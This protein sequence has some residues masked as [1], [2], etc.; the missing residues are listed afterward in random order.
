M[1]RI[2]P[3]FK[4][5]SDTTLEQFK[6]CAI[7]TPDGYPA[8]LLKAGTTNALGNVAL[9]ADAAP[10]ETEGYQWLQDAG[11][12]CW[13]WADGSGIVKSTLRGIF[14]ADGI[15][16]NAVGDG[17]TILRIDKRTSADNPIPKWNVVDGGVSN[18]LYSIK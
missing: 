1:L 9:N 4:G 10:D 14:S 16:I 6:A 18:P 12:F 5:G 7:L 2:H 15:V 8:P 13:Q 3:L 11:G 17:G